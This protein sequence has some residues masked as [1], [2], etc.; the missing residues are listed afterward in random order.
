MSGGLLVAFTLIIVLCGWMIANHATELREFVY[1]VPIVFLFIAI[2]AFLLILL[3][4]ADALHAL[5]PDMPVAALG[6]PEGSVRAFL[7][8]GLL[9][10][11]AVFGAFM[12]F[13]SL[14]ASNYPIVLEKPATKEQA[15]QMRQSLGDPFVLIYDGT[16]AVVVS[17]VPDPSRT[18][19]AKQLLT[20]IATL[21]TTVVGFYFGAR[22]SEGTPTPPDE[23]GRRAAALNE[24]TAVRQRVAGGTA[25]LDRTLSQLEA[26]LASVPE[27]ERT[28]AQEAFEK[29]KA[30][31]EQAESDL[32]AAGQVVA[33]PP[34]DTAPI[35]DARR[36]AS[37]AEE[38]L[39]QIRKALD[40]ASGDV[41]KL[42]A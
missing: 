12:Y 25:E 1:V 40:E 42:K 24:I 35:E 30:R 8:I 26:Q 18:D 31:L 11:V 28:A 7:A 15:E 17:K 34:A 9:A 16:N 20:M 22:T 6:L 32:E 23:Q 33:Q 5:K 10:L 27:A 13:E 37:A 2:G 14:K 21:L 39:R 19:I 4:Y 3:H 29:L 38:S 36:K 41:K